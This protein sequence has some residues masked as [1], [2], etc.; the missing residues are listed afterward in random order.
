MIHTEP[1]ARETLKESSDECFHSFNAKYNLD[2][3]QCGPI[4]DAP[5]SLFKIASQVGL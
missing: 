4:E 1:S 3:I 5:L 2:F